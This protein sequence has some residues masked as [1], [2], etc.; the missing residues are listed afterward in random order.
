MFGYAPEAVVVQ[1]HGV[2][3]FKQPFVDPLY[4]L[5]AAASADPDLGSLGMDQ[6][7]FRFHEGDA[8]TSPRGS[9]KIKEGFSLGTLTEYIVIATDGHLFMAQEREMQ[10]TKPK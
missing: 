3:A 7:R 5:T 1:I 9:G 4:T 10:L 2:G 8:V 6:R